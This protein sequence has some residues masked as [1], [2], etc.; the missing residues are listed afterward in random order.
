MS[1]A[2]LTEVREHLSEIV[3]EVS[4][5][6]TEVTITKHGRAVAVIL[7]ADEYESLIETLNILSDPETMSAIREG[8]AE[9]DD[10]HVARS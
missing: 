7:G 4:T 1:S 10:D 8:L 5:K 3:D 2:P 6:G 9:L